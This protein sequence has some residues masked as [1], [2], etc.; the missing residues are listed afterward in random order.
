M[1]VLF[2][3]CS[4]ALFHYFCLGFLIHSII[5]KLLSSS[6]DVF[7][8]PS[9]ISPF[10]WRIL[11]CLF[12]K[13][14]FVYK[15]YLSSNMFSFCAFSWRIDL[16]PFIQLVWHFLLDLLFI[17]GIFCVSLLFLLIIHLILCVFSLRISIFINLSL[18]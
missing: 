5:F 15:T 2:N 18:P 16:G 7:P 4:S 17:L 8:S 11:L 12:W 3:S 9:L 10:P 1:N 13:C 14:Y 6:V